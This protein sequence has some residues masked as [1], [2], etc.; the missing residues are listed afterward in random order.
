M[1][2]GYVMMNTLRISMEIKKTEYFGGLIKTYDDVP[3]PKKV[4]SVLEKEIQNLSFKWGTKRQF[5]LI[6]RFTVL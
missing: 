6:Y 2:N 4:V 1:A 5:N 3:N